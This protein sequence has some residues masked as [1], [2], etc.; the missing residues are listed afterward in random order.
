MFFVSYKAKKKYQKQ[1]ILKN[2]KFLTSGV[3]LKRLFGVV[4]V[5]VIII[6]YQNFNENRQ[7]F[8]RRIQ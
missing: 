6:L 1:V 4:V 8:Y 7:H 2:F 3:K 5:V